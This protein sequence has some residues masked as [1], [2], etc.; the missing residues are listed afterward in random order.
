M[1]PAAGSFVLAVTLGQDSFSASGKHDLVLRAFED[2][3]T[4][5]G[6][7]TPA[8]PVPPASKAGKTSGTKSQAATSATAAADGLPLQ[9][10]LAGLDLP[11]NIERATAI[12]IWSA[13]HGG[14]ERLSAAEIKSLWAKTHFK[15]PGNLSRDLGVAAKNG[16]IVPEGNGTARVYFVQGFGKKA[17]SEWIAK[18]E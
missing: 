7:G 3:K 16:W 10:Y 1:P 4:L 18:G 17:A 11:T 2:F 5:T 12:L 9:G 13:D 6:R 15:T 8:S 14:K